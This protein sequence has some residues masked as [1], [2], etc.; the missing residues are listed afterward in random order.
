MAGL[1][2]QRSHLCLLLLT[3]S[4]DDEVQDHGEDHPGSLRVCSEESDSRHRRHSDLVYGAGREVHLVALYR[5][6]WLS[7]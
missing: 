5:P 2:R 1:G 4:L 3:R 6:G 7:L